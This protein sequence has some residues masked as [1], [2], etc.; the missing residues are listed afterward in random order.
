[1][2]VIALKRYRPLTFNA[3]ALLLT[4]GLWFT[5]LG[6]FLLSAHTVTIVRHRISEQDSLIERA[7]V[8]LFL[9]LLIGS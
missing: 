3:N 9:C 8:R 7:C 1:M 2:V 6:V 5:V 4:G